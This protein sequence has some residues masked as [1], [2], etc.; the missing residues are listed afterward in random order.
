MRQGADRDDSRWYLSFAIID[1]GIGITAADAQRLF[2]PFVQ[3]DSSLNRRHTGTG[4]G[5]SLVRRLVMAHGGYVTLHSQPDQGSCFTVHL[6]CETPPLSSPLPAAANAANTANA[7]NAAAAAPIT[8]AQ[9][10]LVED[11]EANATT[12]SSYL[13]ARGYHVQVAENGKL[14]IEM[15][16]AAPPDLIVMDIQMPEMDGLEAIRHLRN[17]P[18]LAQVPI[19]A[20]TALAMAG[21]RDACIAAGANE[22]MTKPVRLRPLT[23]MIQQLLGQ[24][25]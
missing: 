3:V 12:L 17:H 7:P 16:V 25:G 8:P 5:L 2:Q 1:T 11:N 6:P 22:Y 4:L 19:L 21:D 9:L 10:L 23:E 20:L 14:A 13:E 18:P 24:G 15:A